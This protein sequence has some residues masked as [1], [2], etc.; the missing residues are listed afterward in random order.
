MRGGSVQN[1]LRKCF[2]LE[3]RL[4]SEERVWPTVAAPGRQ[5]EQAPEEL[6]LPR[7]VI[8]VWRAQLDGSP[9]LYDPCSALLG[10]EEGR[11]AGRFHLDSDRRRFVV[12]RGL[13]RILLGRYLRVEAARIRFNYG[14]G[15]KP[16]LSSP[17][18]NLQFNVSHSG[19]LALYA[20]TWEGA[21]GVDVERVRAI[22]EAEQIAA[23]WF[24]AR[25]VAEWGALPSGQ[26]AEGFLR[27]WTRIEACVK[28]SGQGIAEALVQVQAATVSA[29]S[30]EA[31]STLHPAGARVDCVLCDLRPVR[32]Y[33]GALACHRGGPV[34]PK[35]TGRAV[36]SEPLQY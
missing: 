25:E 6:S 28:A 9:S 1:V 31:S 19:G 26:R 36:S 2:R 15:G 13:L 21:V 20:V 27:Y 30:D 14:A 35:K 4:K 29:R 5:W 3:V 16:A 11:R 8:H 22:P 32:G 23:R 24:S 7:G 10:E 17:A 12:R 34:T 33:V 18:T